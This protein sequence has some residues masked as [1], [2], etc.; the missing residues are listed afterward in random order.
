MHQSFIKT[1]PNV[2]I[3][4]DFLHCYFFSVYYY[5]LPTVGDGDASKQTGQIF[6]E[7]DLRKTVLPSENSPAMLR[8]GKP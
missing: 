7:H 6:E 2:L 1:D 3:I 8:I 5:N 4:D